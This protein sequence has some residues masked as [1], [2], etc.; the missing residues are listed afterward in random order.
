MCHYITDEDGE[1]HHNKQL[2]PRDYDGEYAVLMP[3]D[4]MKWQG[5]IKAFRFDPCDNQGKFEVEEILFI[6]KDKKIIETYIDDNHYKSHHK[7]KV[8]DGKAYVRASS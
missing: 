3:C 4:D 8:E 5:R 7:S 6:G 2:T 1:W